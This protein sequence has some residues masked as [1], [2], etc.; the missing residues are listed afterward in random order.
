MS[1]QLFKIKLRYQPHK[2][3]H[4]ENGALQVLEYNDKLHYYHQSTN[5]PSIT[6]ASKNNFSYH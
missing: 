5:I 3:V 2:Q 4:D 6:S 1:L